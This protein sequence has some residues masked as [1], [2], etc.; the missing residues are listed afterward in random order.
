[1][2]TLAEEMNVPLIGQ[3]PVVQ[4]ICENG[5]KGT[6]AA[7]EENSITGQAFM[8]LAKMLSNRLK[9]VMLKDLQLILWR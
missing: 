3:I 2:K 1:M 8:E 9:N 5:D 7:L 6:P 4:S